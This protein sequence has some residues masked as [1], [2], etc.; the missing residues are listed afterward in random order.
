MYSYDVSIYLR[1]HFL[2][3]TANIK[4]IIFMWMMLLFCIVLR[5]LRRVH[6]TRTQLADQLREFFAEVFTQ[7]RVFVRVEEEPA[8]EIG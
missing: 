1:I 8:L 5:D 2:Y 4:N 7:Q 6:E 3:I